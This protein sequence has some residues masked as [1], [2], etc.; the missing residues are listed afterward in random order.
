[1]LASIILEMNALDRREPFMRV[2]MPGSLLYFM[3]LVDELSLTAG[4]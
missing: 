3:I 1:L 2:D 4:T